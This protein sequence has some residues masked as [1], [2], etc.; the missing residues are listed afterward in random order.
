MNKSELKQ[1]GEYR[2]WLRHE[3]MRLQNNYQ[4]RL[5]NARDNYENKPWYLRMF[6]SDPMGFPRILDVP[7]FPMRSATYEGFLDYQ[8]N[9]LNQLKP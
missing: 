8:L 5:D 6:I 4:R 7:M 1:W 9:Q 3:N 2:E